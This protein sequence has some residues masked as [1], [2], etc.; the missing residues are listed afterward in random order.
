MGDRRVALELMKLGERLHQDLL[1]QV[2]FVIAT[3]QVRTDNLG[4]DRKEMLDKF[5]GCGFIAFL[6]AA[7][8]AFH[9]D[10]FVH[11][12]LTLTN[13]GVGVMQ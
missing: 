9:I 4:N 1:D 10:R 2:L 8:T 3:G 5:L 7:Q 12:V 13:T 6:P 11:L